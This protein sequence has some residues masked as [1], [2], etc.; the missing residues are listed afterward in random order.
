MRTFVHLSFCII[1][2]ST[3]DVFCINLFVCTMNLFLA[4]Y[5]CFIFMFKQHTPSNVI[6]NKI[7][8]K[9]RKQ[10]TTT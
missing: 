4:V 10:T 3:Y 6:M 9:F 5:I 2:Y 1:M 7:L 8:I